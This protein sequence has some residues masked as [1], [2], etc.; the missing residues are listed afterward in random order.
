MKKKIISTFF[1]AIFCYSSIQAQ[2]NKLKASYSV[3]YIF[4]DK[5][6]IYRSKAHIIFMLGKM[7]VERN[8]Y[9]KEW[10]FEYKG[11]I[12]YQDGKAIFYFHHIF[13]PNKNIN[14]YISDKE[15]IKHDDVFY[16]RII[17]DGQTQ[18]AY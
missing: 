4:D 1:L 2:N 11:L 17:F 18:L 3:E 7:I 5:G 6:D 16:Y 13:L 15:I 12:K 14:M 9:T 10:K 8:D